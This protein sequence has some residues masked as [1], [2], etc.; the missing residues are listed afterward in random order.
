MGAAIARADPDLVPFGGNVF[1]GTSEVWEGGDEFR[2]VAPHRLTAASHVGSV[3]QVLF[4]DHGVE[5]SQIM[6]ADH[7]GEGVR[8]FVDAET[9]LI[10]SLIK[11]PKKVGHARQGRGRAVREHKIVLA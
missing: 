5:A 6:T 11:P 8:S 2:E 4:T 7:L 3:L 1:I 10:G 9:S